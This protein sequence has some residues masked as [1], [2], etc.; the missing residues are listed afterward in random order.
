[1]VISFIFLTLPQRKE[2]MEQK[3]STVK[4]KLR[5]GLI[6]VIAVFAVIVTVALHVVL[7]AITEF[8]YYVFLS[9][10]VAQSSCS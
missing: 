4:L 1:V 8:S 2:G 6:S 3:K 10:T 7:L 9:V 5:T